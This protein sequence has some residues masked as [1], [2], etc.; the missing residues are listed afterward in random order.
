[1]CLIA[2]RGPLNRCPPGHSRLPDTRVLMFMPSFDGKITVDESE[3]YNYGRQINIS[4][5]QNSHYYVRLDHIDLLSG[6]KVGDEVKSG[7]QIGT[8]GPMDDVDVA[9]QVNLFNGK[10]VYLSIFQYMTPIAFAPYA[11]M[12]YRPSDFILTK[13]QTD[14]KNYQCNGQQFVRPPGFW[15]QANSQLEGYVSLRANPYQYLYDYNQ[16]VSGQN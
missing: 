16:S 13:A 1:M 15:R 6:L 14:A 3:L 5:A 10:T 12:G 7:Q 2:T 8:A 11:K 9:Y 4:A